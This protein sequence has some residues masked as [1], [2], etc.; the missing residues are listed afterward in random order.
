MNDLCFFLKSLP[1]QPGKEDF[2]PFQGVFGP[3]FRAERPGLQPRRPGGGRRLPPQAA[4]PRPQPDP[5]PQLD[6]AGPPLHH[7]A[8][9]ADVPFFGVPPGGH[10][11]MG[12]GLPHKGVGP[13]QGVQR[14]DAGPRPGGLGGGLFQQGGGRPVKVGPGPGGFFAEAGQ[15]A[16]GPGVGLPE[17]RQGVVAQPVAGVGIRKVGPVGDPSLA[18][19][20][21]V[22]LHLGPGQAQQRPDVKVPRRA[23]APRPVQPGAP[24][25]PEQQRFRLVSDSMGRGDAVYPPGVHPRKAGVAQGPGPGLPAAGQGQAVLPGAADLQRHPQ[26]GAFL[27]DKGFVRVGR[28]PPQLVVDMAGGHLHLQP[29]GQGQQDAQQGHAVRPARDGGGH[30]LPMRKKPGLLAPGKHPGLGI[31]QKR[32]VVRSHGSRFPPVGRAAGPRLSARNPRP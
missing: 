31:P 20:A 15:V 6:R 17:G 14:P 5:R 27:P 19:R 18:R 28:G 3:F 30:P 10:Q 13:A 12:G 24:R 23:D 26:P 25:Q 29:P 9:Q 8:D 16:L 4:L 32:R 7:P 11:G 22:R 2:I 21:A 1:D